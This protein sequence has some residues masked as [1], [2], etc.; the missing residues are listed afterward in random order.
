MKR[1]L[2]IYCSKNDFF[3]GMDFQQW[4]TTCVQRR[5]DSEWQVHEGFKVGDL[6]N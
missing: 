6:D 4:W 2:C 5:G 3:F 1:L